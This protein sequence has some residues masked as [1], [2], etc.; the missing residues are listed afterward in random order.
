MSDRRGEIR[1]W[2]EF[3]AELGIDGLPVRWKVTPPS[4]V[5]VGGGVR[6]APGPGP[7]SAVQRM[8]AILGD[9]AAGTP[10]VAPPVPAGVVDAGAAVPAQRL[11]SIPPDKLL[12]PPAA[13][14]TTPSTP[15][16]GLADIVA[17]LGDC[18]R[19]K[20]HHGRTKIVFGTGNPSAELMFVGE[21]PGRE[22]DLQ[23]LPFVGAA[24]QL[25]TEIIKAIGRTRDDVYIANVVKC[26]PP[27]NR[28][29][30]A[31]EVAACSG[32]LWKQISVVRPKV[33]VALGRPATETLLG[34]P[35]AI[36]KV[37]GQRFRLHGATLVPTFHPAYLLRTPSAKREVW[38]DMKLVRELLGG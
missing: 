12:S 14:G 34:Q 16:T 4:A 17:E 22:E 21:G 8:R 1:A 9:A 26:R 27:E 20:L 35:V 6:P 19:C 33:V 15:P 18:H 3:A 32:F 13:D 23:G 5:A 31:D 2:L 38:A 30:E 7:V 28:T 37:R 29:P 11:E 10:T 24:G 25:L 36:G